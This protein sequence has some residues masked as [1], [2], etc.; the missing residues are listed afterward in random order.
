MFFECW[1]LLQGA[2]E[3]GHD[4]PIVTHGNGQRTSN[5]SS[6]LNSTKCPAQ[7]LATKDSFVHRKLMTSCTYNSPGTDYVGNDLQ[8]M[9]VGSLSSCCTLCQST[10]GCVG[11]T[12]T[13]QGSDGYARGTCF[14]KYP[15][16]QGLTEKD[17]GHITGRPY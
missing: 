6:N 14:T 11:F 17:S 8:S 12:F 9:V 4:A 10:S 16:S 15:I 2:L 13:G 1:M 7:E 5:C 3:A